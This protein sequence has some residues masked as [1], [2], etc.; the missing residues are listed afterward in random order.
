MH[1]GTITDKTYEG[2]LPLEY[3]ISKG[4][5]AIAELL[6]PGI[7]EALKATKGKSSTISAQH[8]A[9]L[10]PIRANARFRQAQ[11]AA[12]RAR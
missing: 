1:K 12:R 11:E 8:L 7:M 10:A 3:A 5:I 4:H 6:R 2:M 9:A